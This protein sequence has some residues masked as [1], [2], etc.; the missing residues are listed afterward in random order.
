MS[1]S[2]YTAEYHNGTAWTA[3]ARDAVVSV[4]GLTEGGG[5]SDNGLAT[6]A[7][8][9][10][11]FSLSLRRSALTT[12]AD[13][14]RVRVTFTIESTAHGR[15]TARSAVGQVSGLAYSDAKDTWDISCEGIKAIIGQVRGYSHMYERVPIAKKTTSSSPT[16]PTST[17]CSPM[18]WLL[19]SAGGW[20]LARDFENAGALFYYDLDQSPFAA[21]YA[22]F[23]GEDGWAELLNLVRAAGGQLY[24]RQDG[25]LVYRQPL[26]WG[27]V[28]ATWTF[29][30][31]GVNSTS[32][33]VYTAPLTYQRSDRKVATE[34][35]CQFTKRRVYPLQTVY[36][37]K[38]PYALEADELRK[39]TIQF[40][41]PL[42]SI[43]TA[44]GVAA[45]RPPMD[46]VSLLPAALVV[47]NAAGL[48]VV[49]GLSGYTHTL[50]TRAQWAELQLR[51]RT[52]GTIHLYQISLRGEPV[53][54]GGSGSVSAGT[55][56]ETLNID[57]SALIQRY[58]HAEALCKLYLDFSDEGRPVYTFSARFNPSVD[59]G[60]AVLLESRRLS[61]TGLR[62]I[63]INKSHDKTGHDMTLD[64]V[65]IE[66]LP[67]SSDFYRIGTTNYSGQSRRLFY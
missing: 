20:P 65:P 62:C 36:E 21:D 8:S 31:T 57:D 3:L 67:K 30:D 54:T 5:S 39:I 2:Y 28:S 11:S 13:K 18:E 45:I 12:V 60:H 66:D 14:L 59:I 4:S 23:A 24:Q 7:D 10:V 9:S 19:L 32:R 27:D 37:E 49:Q 48:P 25:V 52:G 17:L 44:S 61:L 42:N 46:G 16:S 33:Q 58:S 63:I 29:S 41:Q 1:S 53:G 40:D 55:A 38:N 50:I 34:V 64:V 43:E 47:V 56:G 15:V 35:R 22:W 51:N 26:A 6:G